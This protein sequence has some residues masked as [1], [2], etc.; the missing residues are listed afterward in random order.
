[1]TVT[2]GHVAAVRRRTLRRGSGTARITGGGSRRSR[3]E[4]APMA[5]KARTDTPVAT[6]ASAHVIPRSSERMARIVSTPMP[7]SAPVNSPTIAPRKA[8][9]AAICSPANR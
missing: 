9:G 2:D 5:T 6:V 1:M 8:A 3:R 7:R 4:S